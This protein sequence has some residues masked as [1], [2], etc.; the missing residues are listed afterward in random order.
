[1]RN[2]RHLPIAPRV[3]TADPES[4]LERAS[5]N[6]RDIPTRSTDDRRRAVDASHQS[7]EQGPRPRAYDGR[8]GVS[9]EALAIAFTMR[10]SANQRS[11]FTYHHLTLERR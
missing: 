3:P 1:M 11:R 8:T 7:A 10:I 2:A 9:S 6:A 5:R 4:R